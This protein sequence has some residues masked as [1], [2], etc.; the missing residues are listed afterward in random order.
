MFLQF[1][2]VKG[3]SWPAFGLWPCLCQSIQ[4]RQCPLQD[5]K[6]QLLHKSGKKMFFINKYFQPAHVSW[7]GIMFL[8]PSNINIPTFLRRYQTTPS[9]FPLNSNKLSLYTSEKVLF[10]F[11]LLS[12]QEPSEQI[13]PPTICRA[14]AGEGWS[15]RCALIFD[16]RPSI[17][18]VREEGCWRSAA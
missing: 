9:W 18:Q 1:V 14:L 7:K 11:F 8:T 15:L 13:N 17:I 10:A 12:L 16:A 2:R 4:G 6:T 5:K 3:K